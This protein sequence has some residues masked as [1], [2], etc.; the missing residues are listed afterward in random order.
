VNTTVLVVVEE[1]V[2][3]HGVFLLC[4]L[5]MDQGLPLLTRGPLSLFRGGFPKLRGIALSLLD[6]STLQKSPDLT[7]N[8]ASL[9]GGW[10]RLGSKQDCC[11][12]EVLAGPMKGQ[13]GFNLGIFHDVPMDIVSL[14]ACSL[15]R[16]STCDFLLKNLPKLL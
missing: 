7:M 8:S 5:R 6:H 12:N 2:P 1:A 11:C 13:R 16:G 3:N 10:L 15:V 9:D 14:G 4:W